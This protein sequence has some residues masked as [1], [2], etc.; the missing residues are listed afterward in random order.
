LKKN[1]LKKKKIISGVS[2]NYFVKKLSVN[3][4]PTTLPP[5]KKR[6]TIQLPENNSSKEKYDDARVIDEIRT[7]LIK[8]SFTFP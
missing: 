5:T 6:I 7:E 1:I 8:L 4:L 2:N 3:H